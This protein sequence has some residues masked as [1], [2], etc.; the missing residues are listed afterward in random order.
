MS[1]LAVLALAAAAELL[2]GCLDTDDP[3][4]LSSALV[5]VARTGSMNPHINMGERKRFRVEREAS[6]SAMVVV[7]SVFGAKDNAVAQHQR[8]DSVVKTKQVFC[9]V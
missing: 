9:V 7:V 5:E 1:P 8:G 2:T 4:A 6:F 3:A